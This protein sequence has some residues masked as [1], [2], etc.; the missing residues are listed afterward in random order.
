MSVT[1]FTGCSYT[2]GTGFVLEKNDP[3]L[4]A[5]IFHSTNQ[6][7]KNTTCV[8]LGDGA[9][10]NEDIFNNS[11]SALFEYRPRY[12]FVQWTSYPR[13]TILLGLETYP[14]TQKFTAKSPC[15]DHGLHDINYSADYLENIRNRFFSLHHPHQGILNIVK[16]TNALIN[17]AKTTD[18]EIFFINGLCYWDQDYFIVLNNVSPSGYTPCT[19]NL[20]NCKTRADDEVFKIYNRI[21]SEYQAAGSIQENRWLNLYH[22]MVSEK[23]DVNSDKRHPGIQSNQNYADT[24]NQQLNKHL[25]S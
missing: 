18:T 10:S 19:Q 2:A 14:T 8:N 16:Y 20:L 9:I 24:F 21:H 13:Y 5:N 17:I 23:V 4:W 3:A 22:S 15:R 6:Y 7:L 11:I 25:G 1:V 12:M